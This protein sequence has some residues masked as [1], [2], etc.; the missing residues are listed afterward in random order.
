MPQ[1]SPLFTFTRHAPPRDPGS[2]ALSSKSLTR[3]PRGPADCLG[4]CSVVAA[5]PTQ[6]PLLRE[7]LVFPVFPCGHAQDMGYML[8]QTGLLCSNIQL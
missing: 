3:G 4:P 6:E 2:F 7:L 8:L 5:A 1:I